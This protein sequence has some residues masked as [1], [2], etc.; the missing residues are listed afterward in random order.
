M[1]KRGTRNQNNSAGG[2]RNGD[3]MT[4]VWCVYLAVGCT[5]IRIDSDTEGGLG[6]VRKQ[7]LARDY[8]DGDL[9]RIHASDVLIPNRVEAHLALSHA[10][11]LHSQDVRFGD[12]AT[13]MSTTTSA[14]PSMLNRLP[15]KHK[16]A[17][18]IHSSGLSDS[19]KQLAA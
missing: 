6:G 16:T 12:D 7:V 4:P 3:L 5:A 11:R 14:R 18:R 13:A 10:T 2:E 15:M 17:M 9:Q 1:R 19:Y 8:S